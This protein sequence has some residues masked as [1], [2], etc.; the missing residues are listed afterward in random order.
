LEAAF[1]EGKGWSMN[2]PHIVNL[3]S[4]TLT[5]NYKWH[6]ATDVKFQIE[7]DGQ[8]KEKDPI[9]KVSNDTKPDIEKENFKAQ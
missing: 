8:E 1:C 7:I 9:L 4:I 5:G 2:Y 6:P 3:R